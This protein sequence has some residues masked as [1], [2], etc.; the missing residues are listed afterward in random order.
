[1]IMASTLQ[2]PAP[3]ARP[4][5]RGAAIAFWIVTGLLCLWM[6]FTAYAQLCVPAVAAAFREIGFPSAAFRIELSVAKFLG[7]AALLFPVPARI[8]EWAY[9]GFGIVFLSAF[10][11]H[12]SVGQ[13]VAHWLWSVVACVFLAVSYALRPSRQATL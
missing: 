7:I 2:T 4:R 12:T 9:A 1:M 11:A 5:S 13:G 3:A 6:A 10:I 8:R